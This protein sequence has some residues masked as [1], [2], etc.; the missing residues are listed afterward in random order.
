MS[1]DEAFNESNFNSTRISNAPQ[2]LQQ[3]HSEPASRA[4]SRMEIRQSRDNSYN[5]SSTS[6]LNS[7][8]LQYQEI[9]YAQ[10]NRNQRLLNTL[11]NQDHLIIQALYQK[12]LKL[13]MG[14]V[15]DMYRS[16]GDRSEVKHMKII[17]SSYDKGY[18]MARAKH[19]I[20]KTMVDK[21]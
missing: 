19:N 5:N 10:Q 13:H 8:S 18:S 9:N 17:G 16:V 4:S 6:I 2:V 7:S 11:E 21:N 15:P 3:Q 20:L 14:S 1:L 12:D